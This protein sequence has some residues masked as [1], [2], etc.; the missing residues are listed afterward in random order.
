M[1][2]ILLQVVL[3]VVGLGRDLRHQRQDRH[4]G[5]E[6][7]KEP[8]PSVPPD[9]RQACTGAPRGEDRPPHRETEREKPGSEKG[10]DRKGEG[11]VQE[12]QSA[13]REYE[14]GHPQRRQQPGLNAPDSR[15]APRDQAQPRE[16]HWKHDEKP[17]RCSRNPIRPFQPGEG[18]GSEYR[19]QMHGSIKGIVSR[20]AGQSAVRCRL[21][22]CPVK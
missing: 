8:G 12:V 14:G 13:S 6:S 20:A 22:R 9:W 19:A 7:A 3:P 15:E 17:G 1:G 5:C 10:P 21:R 16:A 11:Q 2:E 4:G 18:E